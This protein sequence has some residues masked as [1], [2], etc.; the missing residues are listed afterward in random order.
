MHRHFLRYG[1]SST[2]AL[3]LSACGGG[4]DDTTAAT[5]P[6]RGELVETP[7][8]LVTMTTAE[9]NG[10]AVEAGLSA[11]TG[12]AKCDVKVV[13]LNYYTLGPNGER[14]NSSG[15]LLMPTGAGAG[16]GTDAPLVAYARGTE[17]VK[18]RTLADPTDNETFMLAAMYAAQ[19]YAVVATDYLGYA[20]STFTYHPYLHANSEASS[21]IDS[22]RAARNAISTVG[23][24]LSGKIMLSGYSQGGHASAA[25]QRAIEASSGTEFNIVA[26]AHL[27]GPYNLSGSIKNADYDNPILGYQLFTPF[28]ITSWQK[29]YLTVYT[30]PSIVFKAPYVTDIVSLLPSENMDIDGLIS[31]GKLP[32]GTPKEAQDALMQPA[33]LADIKDN[34]N[35][36]LYAN[37][38]KNDLLGWAPV[39]PT[40]LCGGAAD[41]TVP[42]AM[43]RDVLMAELQAASVTTV[44]SVDVDADIQAAFGPGGAAPTDPMSTEFAE[45]YG[46]YHGMYEPPLCTMRA[47][48]FFDTL[49]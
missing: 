43:H 44:T 26:A 29:V 3:V 12:S 49:K 4:G 1:L 35:N 47:R 15:V 19:G 8:T 34:A 16:C 5:G 40:L 32:G 14:A 11:V 27:A 25:T 28:L 10:A 39:A 37:A 6:A 21:V 42:V 48:A 17:F 13:A 23:G 33:Y 9:I 38:K 46:N 24:T 20:K 7:A 18:T 30:D 22:I 41:P 31:A 36:G 2:F 45:Y